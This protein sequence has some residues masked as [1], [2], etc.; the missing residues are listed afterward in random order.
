[1]PQNITLRLKDNSVNVL[2]TDP[3]KIDP[4]EDRHKF[5]YVLDSIDVAQ[6]EWVEV[7]SLDAAN[8]PLTMLGAFGV[9]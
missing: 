9:L 5:S 2:G 1:M 6:P 3:A 4:A 8:N 7:T